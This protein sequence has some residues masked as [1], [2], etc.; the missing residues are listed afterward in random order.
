[1]PQIAL[2]QVAM[3]AEHRLGVLEAELAQEDLGQAG[4]VVRVGRREPGGDL[5]LAELDGQRGAAA[6]TCGQYYDKYFWQF[7]EFSAEKI[8]L[9]FFKMLFVLFSNPIT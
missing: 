3:Q 5:E 8:M 7:D 9:F 2:G 4:E 6:G 1:V